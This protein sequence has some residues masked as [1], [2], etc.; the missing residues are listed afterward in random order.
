MYWQRRIQG[1]TDW[2]KAQIGAATLGFKVDKIANLSE[3]VVNFL[4]NT[5]VDIIVRQATTASDMCTDL[6]ETKKENEELKEE[7]EQVKGDIDQVKV[8][9]QKVET[10]ASKKD[11]EDKVKHSVTQFKVLNLNLGG[12][13]TDRK[14]L[15]DAAK[16]A[17][18]EKVRSDLRAQYDGSG[19]RIRLATVKVLANKPIKRQV[20]NAEIWTAPVLVTIQDQESRW[21]T[22]D[23]LR[24]SKV[25]PSFHWPREMVENV[26][27]YRQVVENMGISGEDYYVRIRPEQ[28]DGSWRI[29]ADAKEK[30]AENGRFLP[31]ASFEIP[32]LDTALRKTDNCFKPIWVSKHFDNAETEEDTSLTE[33]D[34]IMHL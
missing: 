34:I 11:M 29:R 16:K 5:L 20:D 1:D 7:L 25:F 4:S 2:A 12:A 30:S 19:S 23:I 6:Y 22:E 9:R 3:S 31:V 28:R 21:Q 14:E 17:L 27:A 13:I 24:K 32:P 33:E 8:C 10:K 18:S 15:N 26:K